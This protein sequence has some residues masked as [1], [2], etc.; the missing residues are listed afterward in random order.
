MYLCRARREI[1]KTFPDEQ[2]DFDPRNTYAPVAPH[3]AVSLL[4]FNA[5]INN[6]IVE[7]GDVDNAYRYGLVHGN[8]YMEQHTHSTETPAH[9]EEV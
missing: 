5:A 2:T 3:V 9:P 7:G 6:L 1:R 8:I 4:I